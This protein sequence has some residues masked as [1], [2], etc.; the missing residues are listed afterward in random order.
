MSELDPLDGMRSRIERCRRLAQ[1]VND[2][3]TTA[4]LLEMAEEGEA[5]LARLVAEREGH[6]ISE[7]DIL[8]GNGSRSPAADAAE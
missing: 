5:D 2:P 1:Y 8:S 6:K 4:A 7:N 3:R